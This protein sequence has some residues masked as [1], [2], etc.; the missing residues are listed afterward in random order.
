MLQLQSWDICPKIARIKRHP[1]PTV[2]D[3]TKRD[4]ARDCTLKK[5]KSDG[6][7]NMV[8][9]PTIDILKPIRGPD[10]NP[11]PG[12]SK[13]PKVARFDLCTQHAKKLEESRMHEKCPRLTD[14]LENIYCRREA[15]VDSWAS[16]SIVGQSQLQGVPHRLIRKQDSTF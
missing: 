5:P 8:K 4:T 14:Y 15:I 6:R 1:L 9:R 11:M 3:A 16:I 2:L 12:M 7:V 10:G 13:T